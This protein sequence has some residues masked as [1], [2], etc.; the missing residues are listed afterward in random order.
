M[1]EPT[2]VVHQPEQ[3]RFI[4]QLEG[5]LAHL[6]YALNGSVMDIHHTF[7]PPALR[8]K[9]IAGQLAKAAFDYAGGQAL[10]VIPS[11]SYIGRY[12][13]R[14]PEAGALIQQT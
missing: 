9:N 14:Y 8:G 1:A 6:D 4:I 5:E 10:Q 11:C 12:A 7:V 13:E 3:A 2:A